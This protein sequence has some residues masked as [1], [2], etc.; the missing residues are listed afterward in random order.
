[1]S[2]GTYFSLNKVGTEF[3]NQLDGENSIGEHA[4]EIAGRYK[5]EE[6][7][8]INDLLEVAGNMVE[9]GVVEKV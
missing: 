9:W 6:S 7:M 3:W 4:K 8:V 2:T 1:M 5:V